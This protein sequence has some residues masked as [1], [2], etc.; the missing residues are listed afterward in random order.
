VP[1]RGG[2]RLGWQSAL[3]RDLALALALARDRD[4]DRDLALWPRNPIPAPLAVAMP[5]S[6]PFLTTKPPV[7][8]ELRR[9]LTTKPSVLSAPA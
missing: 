1:G 6:R 8:H 2:A 7:L 3:D 9:F 5:T 4:H